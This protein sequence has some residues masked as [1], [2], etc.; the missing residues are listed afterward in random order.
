MDGGWQGILSFGGQVYL[1]D[2]PAE[3]S[4]T[5]GVARSRVISA[6]PVSSFPPVVCGSPNHEH[7]HG[8]QSSR[9]I[10]DPDVHSALQVPQEVQFNELCTT[11]VDDGA[12]GQICLLTEIEFVFDEAFQSRF[13]SNAQGQAEALV[14]LVEGFYRNDFGILFET[15]TIEL[16]DDLVFDADEITANPFNAG[17]FLDHIVELKGNTNRFTFLRNRSSVLHVVTGRNFEGSTAGI[18][19]LRTACGRQNRLVG[20][21]VAFDGAVGTSQLLSGSISLTAVIVAHEIG[22]NFGA[23]HDGELD[24]NGVPIN[25]CPS[26]GFIMAATANGSANEFSSCSQETIEG[27]ITDIFEQTGSFGRFFEPE[28]CFNFPADVAITS[29]SNNPDSATAGQEV[30]LEYTVTAEDAFRDLASINVSG[31]V[32]ASQGRFNS[33]ELNGQSCDVAAD[34]LSYSCTMDNPPASM[35]LLTRVEATAD[36]V[37]FTQQVAVSGDDEIV[38]INTS[39]N[40]QQTALAVTG[41]IPLPAAASGLSASQGSGADV[42]LS[43][44]D[45]SDNED[46][47]RVERR[48]GSGA[49]AVLTTLA[50]NTTSYTDTTSVGGT[51]YGYR[52]VAVNSAGDSAASNTA[53]ITPSNPTPPPPT[54]APAPTPPSSGGGGAF[55]G[56][57]M[58]FASL[59]WWRR[60]C[61]EG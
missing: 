10:V 41:S 25:S 7:N 44:T 20:N 30:T 17:D 16:A 36:G 31:S 33:V 40:Q 45:N 37:Q 26:S 53:S 22:H 19:V 15:L 51:S 27:Y 61:V 58:L 24:D 14:N 11:T 5:E 3:D 2:L 39:N 46:N 29:A 6:E 12:G 56:L 1:I 21:P 23:Q 18:A 48:V 43:W 50:A 28:R 9:A 4:P 42:S 52:V 13:G 59:L 60:R 47:F 34:E 55:G 57:L 35:M 38:D 49:F 8:K 32:P 54:P